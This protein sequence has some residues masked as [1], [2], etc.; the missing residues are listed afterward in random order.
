ME[1]LEEMGVFATVVDKQSFSEAAHAL[2]M[3]KSSVSRK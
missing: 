2:S 1:L 3:S